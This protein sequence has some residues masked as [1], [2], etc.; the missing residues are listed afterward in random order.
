M[1]EQGARSNPVK[2]Q[3]TMRVPQASVFRVGRVQSRMTI[4]ANNTTPLPLENR[5]LW[6]T[7]RPEFARRRGAVTLA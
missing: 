3:V 1:A 4:K 7:R 6:G 2:I 5:E